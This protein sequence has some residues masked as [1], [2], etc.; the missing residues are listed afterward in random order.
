MSLAFIG[1]NLDL[2]LGIQMT[3]AAGQGRWLFSRIQSFIALRGCYI[4]VFLDPSISILEAWL[5]VWIG[6]KIIFIS[7]IFGEFFLIHNRACFIWK[8]VFPGFLVRHFG[9]VPFPDFFQ[10]VFVAT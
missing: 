4:F 1:T 5:K 6:R 9:L 8:I 2:I 3:S 10:G 7:L